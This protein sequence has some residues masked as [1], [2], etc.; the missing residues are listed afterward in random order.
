MFKPKSKGELKSLIYKEIEK[1][2]TNCSLNHID[3]SLVIDMSDLFYLSK[4][5]GDISAWDTSN[6]VNMNGAFFRSRFNGDISKWNV[7]MVVNMR[8]MFYDSIFNGDISKW[9]VSRVVD[10]REMFHGSKFNGDVS[11]WDVSKVKLAQH[12]FHNSS[13]NGDIEN[14]CPTSLLSLSDMLSSEVKKP[15]WYIADVQKRNDYLKFKKS[16]LNEKIEISK[17][18]LSDPL[19]T[20]T[21]DTK[22]LRIFK[23]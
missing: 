17:M 16:T 8:L 20:N 23:V 21:K 13:F 6:V 1:K 9:N 15:S 2:G 18:L 7:G 3:T 14:W 19:Q 10:M 12:I 22:E 11:S 4:F 5:N